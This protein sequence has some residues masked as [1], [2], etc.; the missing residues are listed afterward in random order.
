[1]SD[2]AEPTTDAVDETSTAPTDTTTDASDGTD[3]KAEAEKWRGLSRK[4]EESFK[5]AAR[6]RDELRNAQMSENE[7]AI[8]E[9]KNAGRAEAAQGF[10]AKLAAAKLE[11][12][13]TG[14]V[15]D[16]AEVIEDL[17]LTA[18]LTDTGDVDTDKVAA[19]K[20]KYTA[21]AKPGTPAPAGSADS[22]PQGTAPTP[23]DLDAQIAEATKSGDVK[24]VIALNNRKLAELA[25]QT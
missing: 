4:N 14:I 2:E 11:A 22:G 23:A 19:L 17:N 12:A 15:T 21:I 7:K 20:A 5:T 18:F 1:M 13:L 10:G 9:A 8:E 3:W 16:P 25:G 6:E 24:T